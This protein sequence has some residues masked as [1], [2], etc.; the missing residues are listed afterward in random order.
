MTGKTSNL[1]KEWSSIWIFSLMNFGTFRWKTISFYVRHFRQYGVMKNVHF[2]LGHPVH[3]SIVLYIVHSFVLQTFVELRVFHVD[4]F[5]WSFNSSSTII[6]Y[7]SVIHTA[8]IWNRVS[9]VTWVN[10]EV[11]IECVAVEK[12]SFECGLVNQALA[13][14]YRTLIKV[15]YVD[16]WQFKIL[17]VNCELFANSLSVKM[18]S[19]TLQLSWPPCVADADIIFLSSGFFFYILSIFFSSYNLSGHRLDVYHTSTHGV[20]LAWI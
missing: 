19:I 11:R 1:H 14:A 2:I 9:V 13:A 20:A 12:S 3:C 18:Q 10:C 15:C 17:L 8:V 5:F 6:L 4:S 7:Y 16:I